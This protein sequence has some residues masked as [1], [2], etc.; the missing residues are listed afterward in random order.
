MLYVIQL[1]GCNT[2]KRL[3]GAYCYCY[4]IGLSRRYQ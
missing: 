3:L 1:L 4:C 2:N